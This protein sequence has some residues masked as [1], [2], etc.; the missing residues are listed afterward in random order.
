MKVFISWSGPKSQ[1]VAIALHG[2]LRG[3]I[4]SVD[5]F[6]SSEDIYAGTRWQSDIAST[7]DESNFGVVCVTRENQAAPWLNF[8]AGALAKAVDTSRVI[9]LAVDLKPA[10]ISLPLGQFQAQPATEDGI[11]AVVSSINDALAENRLPDDLLRKAFDVWWPT[12]KAAL[13]A[14][15]NETATVA[16]PPRPDRE[17]LEETLDTVRSL[18][19]A[20]DRYGVLSTSS[21]DWLQRQVLDRA[22]ATL[23]ERERRILILRFGLDGEPP[24]TLEEIGRQFQLT[25]E[26]VRQL[27]SAGLRK[28]ATLGDGDAD[29][30]PQ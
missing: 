8:E 23:P 29:A 10:D 28:I 11:R 24:K 20:I 4:N 17:I 6:V 26:R 19:R 13:E 16:R 21:Q 9:P 2:W 12:L 14:I 25:R 15:D 27:E 30:S 3:V 18:A 22:L 7:L 1:R 5:P